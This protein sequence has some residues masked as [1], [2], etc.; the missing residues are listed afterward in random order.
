MGYRSMARASVLA[1]AL[2]VWGAGAYAAEP[3]RPQSSQNS[4]SQNAAPSGE[5]I[6]DRH[7]NLATAVTSPAEDLNLRRTEIPDVLQR[8][9]AN[10]YDLKGLDRCPGVRDEILRVDAAIGPDKDAPPPPD[11]RTL[12]EKRSNT[13]GTVVRTGIEW[14][15]PYR[16]VVR[17]ITGASSYQKKVQEA[18]EAGFARRGF[19]KGL[20]VRMN[21]APPAAP[22]WF[23]PARPA[24]ARPIPV[25]QPAKR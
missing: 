8:A 14:L 2:V 5:P 16:G 4:A 9:V 18:V 23:K 24:P 21:C 11:K 10:P 1:A 13:A 22:A 7:D 6:T 25:R 20:G 17:Y 15:T 3:A 19:L 12:N